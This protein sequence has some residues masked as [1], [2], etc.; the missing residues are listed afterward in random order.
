ME[1]K[2]PRST[3]ISVYFIS[4]LG[5]FAIVAGLIY[6]MYSYTRPAPVDELRIKERQ[7]FLT[8]LSSQAKEQLETAGWVDKARGV[9]RLPVARAMELTL[10]E[11]QNPVLGKSNLLVRLE[12]ALP[13]AGATNA[14]AS[15][16]NAPAIK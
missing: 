9:V 8:E 15:S 4:V 6:L 16:T 1:H 14:P 10:L 12:K 13:P 2:T 11:W 7:K 5:T 3:I